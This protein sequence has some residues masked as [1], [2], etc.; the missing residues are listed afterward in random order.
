MSDMGLFRITAC[1]AAAALLAT[2]TT[3]AFAE[4]ST[5]SSTSKINGLKLSKDK[6]IQIEAD[7][8]EIH[9]QDKQALFDGNVQ[10]VQGTMTLNS[11]HMIVFYNGKGSDVTTGQGDIKR[12]EVTGN[13]SAF[14]GTQSAKGDA[15]T[16]DMASQLL[17]LTG[18]QV[19]LVDGSNVFT[20]CKLTVQMQTGLAKLDNCGTRVRISIDPKS[21]KN[22]NKTN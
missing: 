11:N 1:M 5:S 10:V 4:Q 16:Y 15:G 21:D 13:V 2:A 7:H 8:L 19:V 20:G 18:K 14:S 17:T 9:D 6:P 12:I 3:T 22:N